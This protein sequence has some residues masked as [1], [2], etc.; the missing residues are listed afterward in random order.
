MYWPDIPLKGT[1]VICR[2]FYPGIK[3]GR[4]ENVQKLPNSALEKN[5]PTPF[6]PWG[7]FDLGTELWEMYST[8][9]CEYLYKSR[10]VCYLT[11]LP[12]PIPI[13]PHPSAGGDVWVG[14]W[15]GGGQ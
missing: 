2:P 10:Y 12:S 1:H 6:Y 14:A 8:Q 13:P 15:V 7:L 5:D 11:Y 9:I 4:V 3:W